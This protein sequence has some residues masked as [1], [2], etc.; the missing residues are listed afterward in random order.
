MVVPPIIVLLPE[1]VVDVRGV[2]MGLRA[3]VP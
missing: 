3:V 1:P 2:F